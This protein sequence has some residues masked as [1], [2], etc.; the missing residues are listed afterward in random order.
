M[1]PPNIAGTHALEE[2][3]QKAARYV[4]GKNS[5]SKG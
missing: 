5:A 4:Q 1:M 2:K 3:E